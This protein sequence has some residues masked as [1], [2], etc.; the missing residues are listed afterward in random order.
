MPYFHR[1]VT[2][3]KATEV[4]PGMVFWNEPRQGWAF[5]VIIDD[6]CVRSSH[7]F[8]RYNIAKEAMRLEVDSIKAMLAKTAAAVEAENNA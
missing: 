2:G 3:S 8:P 4:K 5:N 6:V 1:Y 7:L